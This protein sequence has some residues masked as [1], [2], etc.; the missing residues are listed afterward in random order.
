MKKQILDQVLH[1]TWSAIALAPIVFLDDKVLAGALSGFLIGAPRE[2]VD[3]WPV[4]H[5][6]DTILDL[7]FFT[8]GGAWIGYMVM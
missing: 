7:A 5:W 2:L 1:F 4:G 8:A 3:Q 6:K